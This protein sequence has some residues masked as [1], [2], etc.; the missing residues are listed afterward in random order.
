MLIQPPTNAPVL[1]IRIR[2]PVAANLETCWPGSPGFFA[3]IPGAGLGA[4]RDR[5]PLLPEHHGL[6]CCNSSHKDG[7]AL[8]V[9]PTCRGSCGLSDLAPTSSGFGQHQPCDSASTC[10]NLE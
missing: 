4:G 3:S 5:C 1:A 7:S 6:S 10:S 9:C 8:D 2:M